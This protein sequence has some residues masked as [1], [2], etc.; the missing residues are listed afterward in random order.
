MSEVKIGV[1]ANVGGVDA[2][3]Q[4]ITASMNKLGSAVAQNQ[5][6]KF[7]P[8]DMKLMA[9][10]LALINKQFQQTLALS[11]QLR[12]A[13][14]AT[15]QSGAH[16]SQIDFSKLSADPRIAQRMRD[17][18]FLHSVRGTALDPT[19]YNETD[20]NGNIIPPAPPGG[21][22]GGGSGG[23][24]GGGGG[25]SGRRPRRGGGG[26]AGGSGGDDEQPT[27]WWRRRPGG[28]LGTATALAAGNGIGGPLGN[29][30]TA[31]IAGGPIG[32]LLAGVTSTIGKG[33]EWAGQ[34]M[35]QAKARNQDLDRLKRSM[36]DLGI[37]FGDLSEQSWKAAQGLSIA[38]G[39]FV[40]LE[41]QAN[42]ASGGAYHTPA[43]LSTATRS[44]ADLGRAY[45]LEPSQ[46]VNFV[47]GMQRINSRQNNKELATQLAEAIV[48]AQSKATPGEVMQEMQ[49]F[50]ASQNR[51]NAVDPNLNVFGNAYGSMLAGDMTAD[52]ASS[53]LGTANSA[54]QHMGGTEATRNFLTQQ[55]GMDPIRAQL[56]AEGGLF[57]NGLDNQDVGTF[58]SRRG[59]KN[60]DSQNKGPAGSNL[61]V[62]MQGLDKAYSG[63]GQY[64]SSMELDAVKNMF[65]LKSLGDAA[66]LANAST[67]D[68]NGIGMV[69]KNAGVDLGDVRE[70]GLQAIAGIS[71]A[72]S[73]D[74]LDKLYRTGPDAIRNRKDMQPGDIAAMDKAEQGGNFQQMQNEM[75]RVLSG[76]GQEDTQATIQ[77]SIDSNIENIKTQIGERLVP[78]SQK[79]M[80]GIL[81]MANK[82]G[83]GIAGP[84]DPRFVGPQKPTD[85]GLI[86]AVDDSHVSRAKVDGM[87]TATG[88]TAWDKIVDAGTGMFN[89]GRR[90]IG[91][92][93][94]G[95][96]EQQYGLP[97]GLLDGVWGAETS[98]GANNR[99]SGAGAKGNFQ[100]L[101]GTAKQYGVTIGSFASESDG[102]ARMYR[103]L[104][105]VNHGDVGKALAGYNWGQG[106]LNEDIKAH[107]DKWLDFAPKET[108]DYIAKIDPK[109]LKSS[110][111]G[112]GGGGSDGG[113][114]TIFIEQNNSTNIGGVQKSKKLYTTINPPTSSGTTQR[115][116]LPG[117]NVSN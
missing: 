21:G 98:W 10:D 4:K 30:L 18:A 115:V 40:K 46:G 12:N 97:N 76:K 110:G 42:A 34:G 64:G 33:M 102:A 109:Y 79:A 86:Q 19:A 7:E 82:L 69:L 63:R 62:T 56:R 65:G 5:K 57:G 41:G 47:S 60:W 101:D 24:G 3:I 87:H 49:S 27:S 88:G 51:F 77:R 73:F 14:K 23:S 74:D 50:S 17:R 75:V 100:M 67:S 22:A 32:A 6:Q 71:K 116:S 37:A 80:D 117:N 78:Y 48:N 15:G 81:W 1:G 105:K 114:V 16:I 59:V 29:I 70:G 11:S 72:G 83:A 106:N 35:D 93:R 54:M 38:N 91:D 26:G 39:E 25:G 111:G 36:G 95:G 96:L 113:G 8:V 43:E 92:T 85:K 44:G 20:A 104:L 89:A 107:G 84:V 94:L 58:M 31:G 66:S 108:R 45:G 61:A 9:R 13:L 55:F 99:T 90:A 53:I 112:N 2:A 68:H 28:S 103:D 52:H